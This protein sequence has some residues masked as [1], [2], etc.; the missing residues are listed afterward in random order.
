MKIVILTGAGV[1]AE[2]GL[3]TFRDKDGLW[4]KY[5]LNEVAT[6]EGFARNPALVHQF[7]NARRSNA[8]GAVP[9]AAHDALARLIRTRPDDVTLITQNVDDLHERAGAT[10]IHM[11]G[12]LFTARC[13]ACAAT[14]PAPQVMTPN[15]SCPE[16]A[17]PAT[18][19][20]VVWFGEMPQHMELIH[21]RLLDADLF[22]AI[23]TSGQV[24]PAAGFVD[25]A[26]EAGA[27]TV[28]IN[29][30]TTDIGGQFDSH[31][32]GPASETVPV[33]V[34]NMLGGSRTG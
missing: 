32:V 28:E 34:D 1:S 24:Y 31:I 29:L 21:D 15:D 30:E 13:H 11:H 8:A 7:Y 6:P 26:R 19:P 12:S 3:G 18:R 22:A 16:C 20:D 25:L 27:E 33:W 2:S 9:N 14:W 10:A 4:T 23:G 17:R 5:D